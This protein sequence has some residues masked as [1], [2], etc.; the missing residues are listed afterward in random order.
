MERHRQGDEPH[1]GVVYDPTADPNA[2]QLSGLEQ[3]SHTLSYSHSGPLPD[4]ATLGYYEQ[5]VPG[6]ADRIVSMAESELRARREDR[7]TLI[8]AEA[9]STVVATWLLGV[10]PYALMGLA[11]WL[12]WHGIKD[13]AAITAIGAVAALLPRLM[14]V[15]RGHPSQDE[16]DST[17]QPPMTDAGDGDSDLSR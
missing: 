17:E 16:S 3:V 15:L 2:Q 9:H 7:R 4:P 11:A 13:V 6:L 8:R 1:D 14:E 5:I 12:A 10:L